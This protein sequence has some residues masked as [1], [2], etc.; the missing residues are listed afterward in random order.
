MGIFHG[1]VKMDAAHG[2]LHAEQGLKLIGD[3]LRAADDQQVVGYPIRI[4]WPGTGAVASQEIALGFART[5]T[6]R[7]I[8]D[9][10]MASGLLAAQINQI[11]QR[12]FD[13]RVGV[14]GKDHPPASL[15][16]FQWIHTF[17]HAQRGRCILLI[18]EPQLAQI[19]G[20]V[21][22]LDEAG[23]LVAGHGW[24]GVLAAIAIDAVEIKQFFVTLVI[25]HCS[26]PHD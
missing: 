12:F 1:V 19:F 21:L 3:I 6:V 14:V 2:V 5:V 23:E 11:L 16:Q 26:P 18:A 17:L 13:R 22:P 9:L 4:C 15:L 10:K 20:W 7:S 25:G 8:I 24:Q